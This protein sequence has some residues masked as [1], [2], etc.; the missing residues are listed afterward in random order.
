MALKIKPAC[1]TMWM[2][3]RNIR[4][5]DPWKLTSIAG[6]LDSAG[7][8]AQDQSAQDEC[9]AELERL[10]VKRPKQKGAGVE[11]SGGF[12]TYL[13]QLACLGLF[14][15]DGQSR[16][17]PTHAGRL[18]IEGKDPARVLR[19][20]LLRMQYPS[21]YG[22]GP[23]VQI[24]PQMKVKPLAFLVK[25]LQDSRLGGLTQEEVAVAV[26]YGRRWSDYE[27]CVLKIKT[28]RDGPCKG[29]RDVIDRLEDICTPRRWRKDD[30]ELWKMGLVD[31]EQIANTALNYLSAAGFVESGKAWTSG[32]RVWWLSEDPQVEADIERWMK[33]A[34]SID[35]VSENPEY[36]LAAQNRYGRYDK[37][38]VSI[39]SDRKAT[40]GFAAL[41]RAAYIAGLQSDPYGFDHSAFVKSQASKWRSSE[42]EI[43][44]RLL[45]I[46]SKGASIERQTLLQASLSGGKEA[47]VLERGIANLFRKLGF[48]DTRHIGQ[49]K[50]KNRVGGFPD[51]YIHRQSEAECGL[52]DTKA[53]VRYDFPLSD[54]QKLGSYYKDSWKEISESA[55]CRFFL[56]VAGNFGGAD[57]TIQRRLDA[58]R[59]NFGAPVSAVTVNA[60]LD[61]LEKDSRPGPR[62]LAKAFQ[63]GRLFNSASQ[64]IVE[65]G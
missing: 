44:D 40:D 11:N 52:A 49:R 21:V 23:N 26:V 6:L 7:G 55:S 22:W 24:S 38:K 20:Q 4:H 53:T 34:E 9:Y 65:A 41:L 61:L 37:Q 12:R 27:K 29:L 42:R 28:M 31:A 36:W 59:S 5:I 13:A 1:R 25:L 39:I 48:D 17:V 50:A 35:A 2:F 32:R 57:E 43:E 15:L 60:L 46:R 8:R 18:V 3:P 56:Y 30:D 64:I 51:I 45:G 58:C 63:A 10:G 19:C 47:L 16:Y 33:E 62:A 54:T 14:Y